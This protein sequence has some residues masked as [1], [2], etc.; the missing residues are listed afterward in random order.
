MK[1]RNWLWLVVVVGLAGVAQAAQP[2]VS[3]VSASQRPGTKLV[4]IYYN[5]TDASG[6][7][8]TVWINVSGDGGAT[9]NIPGSSVSGNVGPGVSPGSGRHIVWNA[10]QDW[11]GQLVPNCKVRV[12]ANDG[13]TPIPPA[14]MALIPGGP[15]QMGDNLDGMSDAQPVHTVQVNAFFMDQYEVTGQLWL[16]VREWAVN[17]AYSIGAGSYNAI[18]HPVHSVSWYDAVK[19]CNARSEKEGLV[20]VYYT[21]ATLANIYKT[22]SLN[23]SNTFVNWNANGYRLPTEAEWEKAARGGMQGQRYPWGDTITCANANYYGCVGTTRPVGSYA[24]NNYGL[25]DM[26]GNIWEW[27]WDW[28]SSTYYVLDEALNNPKG[29]VTGSSR[30][31]RGGAWFDNANFARSAVRIFAFTPSLTYSYPGFRCV[32]GL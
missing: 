30:L 28:Y 1:I 2:V 24:P 13:T 16:N 31:L 8:C 19:W 5:L 32:R 21:D 9:W 15:F 10:G 3:N 27:C 18:T 25:Y 17:N 12:F 22:G 14:G 6:H 23:I 29:P 4:D 26:A 7:A 11:N 20:P